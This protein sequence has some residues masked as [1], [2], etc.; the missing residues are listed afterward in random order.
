MAKDNVFPL[1]L[2]L[3][4]VHSVPDRVMHRITIAARVLA[5][6]VKHT[7][8][9]QKIPLPVYFNLKIERQGAEIVKDIPPDGLAHVLEICVGNISAVPVP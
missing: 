6:P 7:A 9:H 8:M 4:A 1:Q 2:R 5:V 3:G